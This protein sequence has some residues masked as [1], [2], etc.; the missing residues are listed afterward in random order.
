MAFGVLGFWLIGE[1]DWS[2]FD[3]LYMV[4]ITVT[5]VGYNEVLPVEDI[6]GARL[7]TS[8]LLITGMGVSFYFLSSLTAFIIEGDLVESLWR[9]R[10][11]RKLD[12][13]SNHYIV[14]GAGRVGASIAEQLA[15][16]G[17]EVVVVECDAAHLD[18]VSRHLDEGVFRVEGDATEDEL[19]TEV[20]IERAAGLFATLN[21]DR[22]NL[23]LTVSARQLN[24]ELRVVSRAV[25][26]AATRKLMN[27]GA[28]AVVSPNQIGGRRMALEMVHPN[29]IGFVDII[30]RESHH[31]LAVHRCVL[32]EGS[33]ID[34]RTLAESGIRQAADVLV[35]SVVSDDGVAHTFNPPPDFT[36]RSGQTLIA[37]GDRQ[38]AD[39]L[40]AYVRG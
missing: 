27:A 36:L 26:D 13:L 15:M 4:L 2:V 35:V 25:N 39:R 24:P 14:C 33:P 9:R 3:C 30:V 1:G 6:P 28:T 19:L 16:G 11:R 8:V 38:S 20:G 10:M 12:A 18:R 5:T 32:P 31:D 34:G 23:F 29:T 17:H 22:D 7:F 40:Q 21:N 37:L